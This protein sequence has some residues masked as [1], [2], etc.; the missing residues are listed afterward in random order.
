MAYPPYGLKVYDNGTRLKSTQSSL[1]T[2]YRPRVR[3]RGNTNSEKC[4]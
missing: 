3:V 1:R 2:A 4:L